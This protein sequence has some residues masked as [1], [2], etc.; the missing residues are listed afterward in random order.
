VVTFYSYKGGTGRSMALANTAWILASNG[1]RV[2]AIDWDLESPGLHRYFHPFLVDKRIQASPGVID[3]VWD[4]ATA[5][6][7]PGIRD[8]DWVSQCAQ[9]MRYAVSL[10]WDFPGAG[11][12]DFMPAGRQD[13]SYSP[14]V[15]GLD[16][17][18]LYRRQGGGAFFDELRRN[19]TSLYDYVLIDSRTG[20]SDTAGI[21]TIQL[22][23]IL[24]NCFTLSTQSIDGAVFVARSLRISRLAHPVRM[25]P[26]PMRVEDAE[27]TKLE[28]GRDYARLRFRS[29]LNNMDHDA[30]ER[31][32]GDVEIPY[33]PFYA[34]E[35]ILAT[36]GDR[37]RQENSL[38]AAYERLTSVLT[39]N[40][41]V[42]IRPFD[43]V[44]RRRRLAEFERT[45]LA[46]P[47]DIFISYTEQDRIWAEWVAFVLRQGGY[48]VVLQGGSFPAGADLFLEI[49]RALANATCTVVILSPDYL[50]SRYAQASWD[51]ALSR[52]P[53]GEQRLLVPLKVAEFR[54]WGVFASRVA[55]DLSTIDAKRAREELFAAVRT[56]GLPLSRTPE[57]REAVGPEPRFPGAPPTVWRVPPRNPVFVGRDSLLLKLRDRLMNTATATILPQS[58]YGLG[59]VGKTQVAVEFAHRFRGEY[60]L[61]WWVNAEQPAEVRSSLAAL[62]PHLGLPAT[63]DAG[64]MLPMVLDALRRGQPHRRWLLVFDNAD[65]VAELSPL[66]PQGTGHVLI[67]SRNHE[68]STIGETI[69]VDVFSRDESVQL[70]SRRGRGISARDADRLA[71]RLG[72]LPLAI[73]QAAAWQAETG[74]TADEYLELLDERL[75]QLLSEGSPGTYASSVAATWT[76]A[77][78]RLGRESPAAVQLLQLSAFFGSDPI[79]IRML[80]AGR[81]APSLPSPLDEVIKDTIERRR[82]LRLLSRYALARVDPA[83]DSLQVHRLVQA[84]LRQRLSADERARYRRATHEMLVA[85]NPGDPDNPQSHRQ[86]AELSP[87]IGPSRAVEGDTNDVRKVVLDQIRYRDRRGDPESSRELAEIARR[88]W[89]EKLGPND[90]QTLIVS[91]FLAGALWW[92]GQYDQA[93][94]LIADTLQR[95]RDAFGDDH[96][97]TLAAANLFGA[98]LRVRGRF[99]D[100]LQ[101]DSA[102]LAR[103]RRVFGDDDSNT[104][105]SAN[106]LAVDLRLLGD[107]QRARELDEET[108]RRRQQLLRPE[109]F[110][111]LSSAN[112]LARD[113]LG[114]GRYHDANKVLADR[115]KAFRQHLGELHVE[116]LRAARTHTVTLRKTGQPEEARKLAEQ[117]LDRHRLRFG[118]MHHDTLAAMTS[119]CNDRRAVGD[120]AAARAIGEETWTRY[121]QL[122]GQGHPFTLVSS[123]NFAIVLRAQGEF[124]AARAR[125]EEALTGLDRLFGRDNLFTLCSAISLANDLH[126]T[127]DHRGACELSEDTFA[128]SRRVRGPDHP[129]TLDCAVNLAI[130]LR[131]VGEE[132]RAETLTADVTGRLQR[133][134]GDEDLRTIAALAGQRAESDIEPPSV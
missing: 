9:V 51:A 52:D 62:A 73:E 111:I 19:M 15:S 81:Y 76:L 109:N 36:V 133:V 118:E 25:L 69:E 130:D 34:Y 77:F 38:L 115:L 123:V 23:D 85:A 24:V 16:W 106:N 57:P 50:D 22:P 87:H 107:Y 10:D 55:I 5:A 2:L 42:E 96:E 41:V 97:H 43:E 21:C 74:V 4:F 1:L 30:R 64:E 126:L 47:S 120:V 89:L 68:W 39:E 26:V 131:E 83:T 70:I 12:L 66:L 108:L 20:L 61:V 17:E 7:D 56:P 14:R 58:L 91:R 31:Y 90:A 116:V 132:D 33:K 82:A 113:L 65:D 13:E 78:D 92:L 72:D 86:H 49:E 32:W 128:R 11:A 79:P 100:A 129:Y 104:L 37:P 35:E 125:D 75:S 95:L 127:G 48:R 99:I 71:E 45:K 110:E 27:Q 53:T 103:H 119:V 6:M 121:Q 102:G 59:G 46:L 105:R 44:E 84:V 101:H 114:L 94:E 63:G 67:T 8:D 29:F 88:V 3:L 80:K 40:R 54:P 98:D 124:D 122:F 28:A 134:F 117:N 60:D 93:G 18:S 112:G